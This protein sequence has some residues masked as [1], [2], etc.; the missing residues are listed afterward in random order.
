M[1]RKFNISED[2]LKNLYQSFSMAK[3]AEMKGVGETIIHKRIHEYGITLKDTGKGGHRKKRGKV[4][5]D[6]HKKNISKS[7]IGK[8]LG[9]KHPNWKGGLIKKKCIVCKNNYLIKPAKKETSSFCSHKCHGIWKSK[10]NRGENHPRWQFDRPVDKKCNFC[11]EIM[12]QKETEAISTYRARKFCSKKCADKGGFRYQ[13]EAHPCYKKDS[14]KKSGR[15][16][17]GAWQ[18]AVISRDKAQCQKCGAQNIQLHAHHINSF[19]IHP[20]KRWDISNGLTLCHKCHEAEHGYKIKPDSD[21]SDELV[22]VEKI[23]K[24]RPTRRW[25]GYCDW[26]KKFISKR[27]SDAKGQKIHFCNKSCAQRYRMNRI[28][29]E[30]RLKMS[31]SQ[32]N[33]S[34]KGIRKTYAVHF[35]HIPQEI[36][37]III[38]L[39]CQNKISYANIA[40]R[41]NERKH[42]TVNGMSFKDFNIR[43]IL[44][45][46]P[47]H[48]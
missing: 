20:D 12:T 19:E 21:R 41:M 11:N 47:F 45:Q 28:T 30:T 36:H 5:S 46:F 26:C 1:K 15:G 42:K 34:K 43:S 23:I 27:W 17:Q 25:N 33:L 22:P 32:K 16:K 31:E 2:E 29:K 4:F 8:I 14:R 10:T 24:G 3:I 7:K 39:N 44:N 35:P 18:R 13:G 48:K 40:S 9:A 6:E 37:N 38:E